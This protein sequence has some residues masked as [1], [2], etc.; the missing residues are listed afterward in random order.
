MDLLFFFGSRSPLRMLQAN[1][2]KKKKEKVSQIF[3]R[4]I[5][6]TPGPAKS[7]H[8]SSV[9]FFDF[10]FLSAPHRLCMLTLLAKAPG[11][12]IPGNRESNFDQESTGNFFFCRSKNSRCNLPGIHREIII[13]GNREFLN[14]QETT[15]NF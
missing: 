3:F 12:I 4:K 1:L 15:R 10:F 2:K 6:K 8:F 13:R 5:K 9:L 11:I 14:D 7:L